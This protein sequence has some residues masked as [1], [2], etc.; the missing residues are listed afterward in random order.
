MIEY[1]EGPCP[2]CWR[3]WLSSCS[4]PGLWRCSG[5]CSSPGV[6]P[7]LT[8]ISISIYTATQFSK[9]RICQYQDDSKC[10]SSVGLS[11]ADGRDSGLVTLVTCWAWALLWSSQA[12]LSNHPVPA[13]N[14]IS[15]ENHTGTDSTSEEVALMTKT[16]FIK[17]NLKLSSVNQKVEV[18]VNFPHSEFLNVNR[19]NFYFQEDLFFMCT[20]DNLKLLKET[21]KMSW[22]DLINWQ[23]HILYEPLYHLKC[24]KLLMD[25]LANSLTIFIMINKQFI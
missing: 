3:Q 1:R 4:S 17:K 15:W 25:L 2:L 9:H 21:D 6:I 23:L 16:F 13:E 5:W 14:L 8:Q 22:N 7:F 12:Q 19:Q 11:W 24:S 20:L 10:W 18:E